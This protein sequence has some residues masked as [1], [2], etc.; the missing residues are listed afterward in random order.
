MWKRF[1]LYELK[2]TAYFQTH[3]HLM[4]VFCCSN[5]EMIPIALEIWTYTECPPPKKEKQI[6]P[7][8]CIQINKKQLLQELL[9]TTLMPPPQR[10]ICIAS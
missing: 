6:K 4:P 9:Y 5:I 3:Q 2:A 10:V 1:N 8:T 7:N